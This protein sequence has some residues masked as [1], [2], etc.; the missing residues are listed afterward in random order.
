MSS[1][2]CECDKEVRQLKTSLFKRG[3]GLFAAL[4]LTGGASGLLTLGE[5][6][7]VSGSDPGQ[8][9]PAAEGYQTVAENSR[10]VLAVDT[11]EG[12]VRLEDKSGTAWTS[13]PD[14]H[15]EDPLAQGSTKLAMESLLQIEYADKIGNISSVNGK[16][17]SVNKDGLSC[18]KTTG[19]AV[20]T[21]SFPK[22]GFVIPLEFTLTEDALDVAILAGEIQE[23]NDA[24]RLTSLSLLPY[25]GAAGSEED[26]YL[27]VPDGS[28][29]LIEWNK[30]GGVLDDYSQYVYGREPATSKMQLDKLEETAYL[31]VFGL[32]KGETAFVGIITQGAGR[33]IVNASVSGKRC[34]YSN[35]Y[36]QFIYRDSEMV[37]IEQKNQTV[38]VL[39][40]TPAAAERY[41]VRYAFLSGEEANYTGM[42]HLYGSWLMR[43]FP[44]KKADAAAPLYMELPGG[45]MAQQS[46]LGFPI[47]RVVPLTSYR[48]VEAITARMRELGAED[49]TVHYRYWNKGGT[50]A[51]IPTGIEPEGRLGGKE[52]FRS[53]LDALRQEDTA[54]YLDFNFTDLV[55]NRWGYQRGSDS[56]TSVRQNLALQFSYGINTLKALTTE[57][58]TLLRLPKIQKAAAKTAAAAATYD[59]TGIAAVTL[60]NTLYSD[61]SGKTVKRDTADREWA[62]VLASLKEAKGRQLL[63]AACGYALPYADVV[64]S[65]PIYTSG[66]PIQTA[67]VPFYQIALH[68]FV[69]MSTPSLNLMSD[70][71]DGILKALEAGIGIQFQFVYRETE[72]PLTD[73]GIA[74][75]SG[76]LFQPLAEE[77]A[78]SYLEV[79]DILL[80]VAGRRVVSHT[81][82]TNDVRETVFDNGV[83]ILVNYGDQDYT[84]GTRTVAAGGYSV[85]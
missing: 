7:P 57:S 84:D 27:F 16:T 47:E 34:S 82:L 21:F 50:G 69:S 54:L 12:T 72:Q 62:A 76:S 40:K 46:V 64:T 29:A 13:V 11:A 58:Y 28:G 26:G 18:R 31:P 5:S 22:E 83:R 63:S 55:K 25:F 59:F 70:S 43:D 42:A 3:A 32:K 8:P 53:M 51:A 1:A 52:A 80:Q 44:S 17:A 23:T 85:L 2:N 73:S 79:R 39:E 10:F 19:G 9:L 60:G 68:E 14:G 20:L 30:T 45:V 49:L 24:Y 38:R 48:D 75:L 77:A 56:V 66:Y 15:R 74:G 4:L 35:V 81:L 61:F 71:R 65:T 33:A 6:G 41:G 36:A 67:A 78:A 37:K